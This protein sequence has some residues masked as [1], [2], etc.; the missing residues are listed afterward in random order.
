MVGSDGE[1]IGR[2]EGGGYMKEAYTLELNW[3]D[4]EIIIFQNSHQTK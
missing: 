3:I 1:G 4:H 2:R